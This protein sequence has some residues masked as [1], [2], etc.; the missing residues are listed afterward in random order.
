MLLLLLVGLPPPLTMFLLRRSI[1]ISQLVAH[2]LESWATNRFVSEGFTL[3][4]S[5][6]SIEVGLDEDISLQFL[7][8]IV[9]IEHQQGFGSL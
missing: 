9:N 8:R 6:E 2:K 5:I 7:N 4:V 3:V 1:A